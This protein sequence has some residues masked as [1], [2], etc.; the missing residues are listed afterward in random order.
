MTPNH[1]LIRRDTVLEDPPGS[2]ADFQGKAAESAGGF[3]TEAQS[4]TEEEGRRG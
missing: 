4:A 2:P 1:S 3:I